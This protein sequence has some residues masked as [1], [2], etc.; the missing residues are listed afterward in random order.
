PLNLA[1][2]KLRQR[3]DIRFKLNALS[4]FDQMFFSDAAKFWVVQEQVGQLASLLHQ[5]N[6]RHTGN[7][8]LESR[9]AEQFAQNNPGVV[10]TQSVIEI[11]GQQVM[12][13]KNYFCFHNSSCSFGGFDDKPGALESSCPVF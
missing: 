7:F 9:F 5:V 6:P 8:L 13:G 11:T 4:N 3:L 12:F 2:E 1:G 10:A